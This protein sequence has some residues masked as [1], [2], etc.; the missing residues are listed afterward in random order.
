[1]DWYCDQWKGS[2]PLR[3]STS[4]GCCPVLRTAAARTVSAKAWGSKYGRRHGQCPFVTQRILTEVRKEVDPMPILM[5]LPPKLY[6]LFVKGQCPPFLQ[7]S[8]SKFQEKNTQE[9]TLTAPILF[10]A[11]EFEISRNEV[12]FSTRGLGS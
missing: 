3:L 9:D 4:N 6:S 7:R 11:S 5:F 10:H 12:I 8:K 1:M 2:L